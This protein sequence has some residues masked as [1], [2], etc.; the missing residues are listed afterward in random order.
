[1]MMRR[2]WLTTL[3]CGIPFGLIMAIFISLCAG[4]RSGV[5]CG[6]AAGLL[7]GVSIAVCAGRQRRRFQTES[8]G[9]S[10]T[11]EELLREGPASHFLHGESIGGW[12][13]LTTRRLLFRSHPFNLQRH[14]TDLPLASIPEASPVFTAWIIPNGLL[15]RTVS[16]QHERFVVEQH[17][18]WSE[19]ISRARSRSAAPSTAPPRQ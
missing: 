14:D 6:L 12:L 10:F 7:F 11:G 5:A 13:Y 3:R 15:V 1:M 16:G 2:F 17:E 8:P 9:F 18:R 4:W 19:E